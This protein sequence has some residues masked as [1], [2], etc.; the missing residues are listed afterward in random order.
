MTR[1]VCL[2]LGSTRIKGG[3]MGPDGQLEHVFS[4]EAP[5]LTGKGL[6]REGDGLTYLNKAEAMVK[7]VLQ[8]LPSSIP[9]GIA[10]QR[11]S[12]LLWDRKRGQPQTPLISWQDRRAHSWCRRNKNSCSDLIGSTGL[13]LSPHYVGPKLA[14][15]FEADRELRARAHDGDLAFGTLETFCL[16]H[17]SNGAEH[18]TDLSM[19]ARTLLADP[20]TGNW[21][22]ELLSFFDVDRLILPVITP[23]FGNSTPLPQKGVVTATIADQMAVGTLLEKEADAALINMGT[24]SFVIMPTGSHLRWVEGYL[25]GPVYKAPEDTIVYAL[26]GTVNNVAQA[27]AGLPAVVPRLT[28]ED[29]HPGLFCLP[30]TT[31]LG[32]PYWLADF[33]P[34]CSMSAATISP[35]TRLTAV[36]EGI[37]FRICQII[38]GL[39]GDHRPNTVILS[40]G[41]ASNPFLGQGIATC[42]GQPV[43]VMIEKEATLLG[44]GLLAAGIMQAGACKGKMV[45]PYPETCYLP[46]K[47]QAWQEWMEQCIRLFRDG[48]LEMMLAG[49]RVA[50]PL[51]V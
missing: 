50:I 7:K 12:F 22:D 31:G 36:L 8:G 17:W 24:G 29:S 4:V 20:L 41:L 37:V 40:G 21:S 48:G 42:L 38:A 32:S 16:W 1:A 19:A 33:P 44:A 2:D 11:S 25:S 27:L 51:E 47:F 30:E 5:P 26:E 46:D 49:K 13:R 43:L 39:S 9:I 45:Y 14:H 35:T 15:L 34:V 10:C 18:R 6:I 3:R 23:T 28:R